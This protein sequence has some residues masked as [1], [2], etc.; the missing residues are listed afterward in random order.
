MRPSPDNHRELDISINLAKMAMNPFMANKWGSYDFPLDEKDKFA[1]D[2][3]EKWFKERYACVGL[4]VDNDSDGSS[5][6]GSS[7]RVETD[8]VESAKKDL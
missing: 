7:D 2:E 3:W 4:L 5:D 6:A 8:R 1:L